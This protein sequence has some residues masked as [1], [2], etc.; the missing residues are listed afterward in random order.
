MY[1]NLH[2]KIG[3]AALKT[4]PSLKMGTKWTV[5]NCKPSNHFWALALAILTWVLKYSKVVIL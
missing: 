5:E 1:Q 4:W 3:K 2:T